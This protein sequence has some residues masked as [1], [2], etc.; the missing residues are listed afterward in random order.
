MEFQDRHERELVGAVS[1][2]GF[3][4][5]GIVPYLNYDSF[6]FYR[7]VGDVLYNVNVL[8]NGKGYCLATGQDN[9]LVYQNDKFTLQREELLERIAN[10][11]KKHKITVTPSDPKV[12]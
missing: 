2:L 6:M 1:E 10:F 7:P 9:V 11:G 5:T 8:Y 3:R 4:L 12:D